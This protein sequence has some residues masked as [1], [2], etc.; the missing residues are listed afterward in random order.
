[1]LPKGT[2]KARATEAEFGFTNTGTEQVAV[3]FEVVE[4][5]EFQGERIAWFGFFTEATAERTIQALRVCGW[6]GDDLSDLSGFDANEVE[7]VV[8]HEEYQGKTTAKV[9]WVNKVGNRVVLKHKMSDAQRTELAKRMKGLAVS[10]R[11]HPAA[12]AAPTT[13]KPPTKSQSNG[14]GYPEDWDTQG[15]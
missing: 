3:T 9:K 13:T 1:M 12:G 11:K 6:T 2:Y 8:E 14:K 4:D 7:L 10:T 15:L 5:G